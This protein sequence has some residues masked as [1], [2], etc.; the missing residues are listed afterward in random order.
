MEYSFS[1]WIAIVFW[2]IFFIVA[3][4]I[5]VVGNNKYREQKKE[6]TLKKISEL[7][8]KNLDSLIALM[9]KSID[10]IIEKKGY[11]LDDFN[12]E[13]RQILIQARYKALME[14]TFEDLSSFSNKDYEDLKNK[15]LPKMIEKFEKKINSNH[16]NTQDKP[17]TE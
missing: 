8:D 1:E 2:P 16:P 9:D 17:T 7:K 13:E 15:L 4:I 6:E 5:G 3:A 14:K 11:D 10:E 12:D